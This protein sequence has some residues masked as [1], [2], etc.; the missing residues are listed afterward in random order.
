MEKHGL[1]SGQYTLPYNP[2]L[3]TRAKEMRK[4]M[5]AA[6]RKIWFGYLADFK[7]KVLRQKPIDNYIVDFYIPKLK[8]II[9]I[10]G[11]SHFTE[12]GLDYDHIRTA[13]LESYNLIILR[14]TN[15][16]VLHDFKSVCEVIEHFCNTYNP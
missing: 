1:I 10:D 16:E 4:N 3:I 2:D 11:A 13:V 5:T 7:Y 14:F 8:L 6:E 9:E 15:N 12:D